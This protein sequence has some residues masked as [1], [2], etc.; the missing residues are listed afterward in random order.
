MGSGAA[1]RDRNTSRPVATN[2]KSEVVWESLGICYGGSSQR[3]VSV[4]SI[5]RNWI[6]VQGDGS[7][8]GSHLLSAEANI[9]Q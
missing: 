8:P 9:L 6:R 5:A 2:L 3:V 7:M 4:G 1:C